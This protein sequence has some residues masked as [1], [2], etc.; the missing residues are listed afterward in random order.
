MLKANK[1]DD[2]P[3]GPQSTQTKPLVIKTAPK[4]YRLVRTHLWASV[5][6]ILEVIAGEVLS[7]GFFHHCYQKGASWRTRVARLKVFPNHHA[8]IQR[9]RFH[10]GVA[11]EF[12][13]TDFAAE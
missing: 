7:R 10:P 13:D 1:N 5:W 3:D 2:G 9:S 12:G 4:N 11:I 6:K 8:D